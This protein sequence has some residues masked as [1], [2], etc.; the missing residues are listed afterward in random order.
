MSISRRA[1]ARILVLAWPAA[2]LS[3][4]G[5]S[6]ASREARAAPESGWAIPST[7]SGCAHSRRRARSRLTAKKLPHIAEL[8][9]SIVYLSP[10]QAASSLGGKE[11]GWSLAGPY[12]IQDYDRIDP[13]YG[14]RG[15]PQGIHREGPR[16]E[17]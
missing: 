6:L 14:T 16:A 11:K 1:L 7:R 3:G 9:A 8:G 13:E 4:Q 10:L 2:A 5:L 12:G 17:A 15:R